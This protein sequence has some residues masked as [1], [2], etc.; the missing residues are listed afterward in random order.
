MP[1]VFVEISYLREGEVKQ[2][3][4]GPRSAHHGAALP[5]KGYSTFKGYGNRYCPS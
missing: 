5:L 4:P 1:D 3:A 2:K